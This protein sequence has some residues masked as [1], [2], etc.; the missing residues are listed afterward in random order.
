MPAGVSIEGAAIQQSPACRPDGD[1]PVSLVARSMLDGN[2]GM[3]TAPVPIPGRC[4]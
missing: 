1:H 3:V 4:A 2:G